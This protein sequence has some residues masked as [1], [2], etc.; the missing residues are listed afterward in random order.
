VTAKGRMSEVA[1]EELSQQ[2]VD[3]SLEEHSQSP[4]D[5]KYVDNESPFQYTSENS[6]LP[7]KV[8]K[9]LVNYYEETVI[10]PTKDVF[11]D[12]VFAVQNSA[13]AITDFLTWGKAIPTQ[14]EDYLTRKE[15]R[16]KTIVPPPVT[17]QE[18]SVPE[19]LYNFFNTVIADGESEKSVKQ[20]VQVV[21][22]EPVNTIVVK[23]APLTQNWQEP[24]EA[25]AQAGEEEESDEEYIPE[26][27]EDD[28]EIESDVILS[29]AEEP[30]YDGDG[31]YLDDDDDDDDGQYDDD[32]DYN[33]D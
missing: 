1:V 32:D 12:T 26:E 5:N 21:T 33:E 22:E 25:E 24:D 13:L 20:K 18:E 19:V 3:S 27:D 29:E 30:D 10:A 31:I 15:N 14:E 6:S 8:V 4:E 11:W 23:Q 7:S 9:R 2:Q 28:P 16:R 17:K